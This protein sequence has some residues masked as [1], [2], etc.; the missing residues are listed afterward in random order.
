MLK[1]RYARLQQYMN[2]ELPDVQPVFRKGREI[3]DKI[4]K[5]CWIIEKAKELQ[6]NIYLCFFNYDQ[7]FDYV[8]HDRLW[9]ALR[10]MGIPDH[11]TSLLRNL[12]V[13]QEATVRTMYGTSDWFKV[14]R[15]VQQ[16]CLL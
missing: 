6:K 11:L 4:V 13:G 10:E 5:I 16:G 8:D 7:A 15:G 9:T 1:I 3:R 2:Q 14:E 12:Y